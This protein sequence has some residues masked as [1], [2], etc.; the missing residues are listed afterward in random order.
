MQPTTCMEESVPGALSVVVVHGGF[1][2][3]WKVRQIMPCKAPDFPSHLRLKLSCLIHLCVKPRQVECLRH[4][5][6]S[7]FRLRA[8][9]T[10]SKALPLSQQ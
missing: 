4:C 5:T 1:L 7:L 10:L 2:A 3:G 8:S 9:M 6:Y